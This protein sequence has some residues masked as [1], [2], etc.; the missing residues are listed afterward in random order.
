VIR[1]AAIGDTHAN[2]HRRWDEHQRVMDWCA[3]DF[4]ARGIDLAL[5]T[6]D[7]FEG[8]STPAEREYV[9]DWTQ[10]AAHDRPIVITRGNHDRELELALIRRLRSKYPI[11]VDEMP[12]VHHVAARGGKHVAVATLPWPR[13]SHLLQAL[14][15]PVSPE[16]SSQAASDALRDILRGM[17]A[18]LDE[19]AGMPRVLCAHVSVSGAKTNSE[20][21][22]VGL[23]MEL[24]TEDLALARADIGLLGHIHCEQAWQVGSTP[25]V[26][27]SSPFHQNW[28]EF[29]PTSYIVAEFEDDGRLIQWY[30]VPTPA[31]QMLLADME[32]HRWDTGESLTPVGDDAAVTADNL[33]GSEVRLRYSTMSEHR[34]AAK[35]VA[36]MMRDDWMR[37]GAHSVKLE[38]RVI[39]VARSRAPEVA[40]AKTTADKL[41]A[42]WMAK[43]DV[44]EPVRRERLLAKLG[45]LEAVQ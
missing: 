21:P 11:V 33:P 44:P 34:D 12:G 35:R 37:I 8:V 5:H 14:G 26:Y 23:D 29:G 1:I 45:E 25:I 3:A 19:Y 6:G 13:K 10:R 40:A 31:R 38:E 22:L 2:E 9:A 15:R 28:G 20:Q 36:Q 18:E 41:Q 16:E 7:V 42:F 4:D 39:S 17:G 27:T 30:R 43:D 24:S 32:Y